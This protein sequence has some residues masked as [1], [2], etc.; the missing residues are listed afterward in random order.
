MNFGW[1]RNTRSY[2]TS[3]IKI[4]VIDSYYEAIAEVDASPEHDENWFYPPICYVSKSSRPKVPSAR[5]ELPITHRL[6]DKTKSKDAAFLEFMIMYYG[7]LNGQR[8]NP[9]GWGHLTKAAIMPGLLTDFILNEK[10]IASLLDKAERF[11]ISHQNDGLTNLMMNAIHWYLYAHSYNQYFERFMAQ[12]MVF[13][14]LCRITMHLNGKSSVTHRE[15]FEY[16]SNMLVIAC[17]SWGIFKNGNTE[18]AKIRNDLIHESTFAGKPI[19]FGSPNEYSHILISL[20][21]FNCRAI[22]AIIGAVG[23]YSRSSCETM[24]KLMFHID[25]Q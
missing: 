15:R 18:I 17:P 6:E 8:L 4:S 19:G 25:D 22:A 23:D 1:L 13:D 10:T 20:E 5:F 11:W 21:A 16:V 3:T 24:Q 9:E 12:Y 14:T 7:W 2:E